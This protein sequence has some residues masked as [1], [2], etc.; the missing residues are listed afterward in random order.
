[1]IIEGRLYET[2]VLDPRAMMM[3]NRKGGLKLDSGEVHAPMPGLIVDVLVNVGDEVA[4]GD[5][6]VVLESMKM[7]NELKAPRDGKVQ[8]INCEAGQSVEKG[9]LLINRDQIIHAIKAAQ[10]CTFS[11]PRGTN[12]GNNFIFRNV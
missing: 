4:E 1:M 11:T 2:Q 8:T 12:E 10:N 5:T 6:V 7:Q 9:N 3:L